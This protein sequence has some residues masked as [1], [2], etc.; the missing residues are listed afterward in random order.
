MIRCRFLSGDGGRRA[1]ALFVAALSVAIWVVETG[2]TTAD[3]RATDF[4]PDVPPIEDDPH[5][6]FVAPTLPLTPEEQREKFQLPPGFEIQLVVAEP[7][8][9]KPMNLNFDARGRLW[10]THSVEYPWPAKESP[11]RDGLTVLG[12]IGADGRAGSVTR[13]ADGL[14]IP[15]GVLP[16]PGGVLAYSIPTIDFFADT[17][18]DGKADE[19][20]PYYQSIEYR[21]THGMTNSFTRWIDGWIYACHGFANTSHLRGSDGHEIVMNSGNTYRMR[22]DGSHVEYFTHGQVNPF[23][24]T[25]D[26][27][28]N[29]YSSDCHTKPLYQLLRGA[30]YPSFGK[31]HDGLGFGPTTLEHLHGSTGIA[32]VVYYAAEQFPAKYCDTIFI[33]NPVTGRINHDRLEPHG[34]SY[35]AIEQP[36]FV[37]CEDPWFRPV[38]I[39]LGPDGAMY[40]ADFYNCIIGHYEVPLE[41]PRRD[42]YRGRIWRVVYRGDEEAEP[43]A[44]PNFTSESLAELLDRLADE[45]LTV[46]VMATNEICDRFGKQVET[47][48]A[49]NALLASEEST[50]TQRAHGM[51]IVER[52]GGL[53]DG[54]IERFAADEGRLVRV[55]VTKLLAERAEWTSSQA[56]LASRLLGDA[57]PFVRRAA[58]DALGRHPRRE[59]VEPLLALWRETP[60]DDTHLI[61][62]ARMALRDHLRVPGMYAEID[63]LVADDDVASRIA[64]L[65]IGVHSPESAAFVLRYLIDG[66]VN[67]EQLGNMLH[68]AARYVSD[69]Q[70]PSIFAYAEVYD[71]G[72]VDDQVTVLRAMRN[73]AQE[74]GKP[75]FEGATAWA[76]RLAGK[77]LGSSDPNTTR[78]GIELAREFGMPDAFGRIRRLAQAPKRQDHVRRAAMEALVALDGAR[79]EQVLAELLAAIDERVTIRQFAANKLAGLN[80]ES[81]RRILL[82]QLTTAPAQL[83]VQIAQVL[84]YG[85]DGAVALLEAVEAGKASARLLKETA[86]ARQLTRHNIPDRDEQVE[87][88]TASLPPEDDRIQQLIAQRREHFEQAS[89]DA[90]RGLAVYQ[91]N[92]SACHRV[93]NEGKKIGP[94]LDGVGLRGPER[95]IEDL[96]DPSRNVDQA[97][98]ATL[99]TTV[100]GRVVSGLVLR[101]EGNV[102]ILADAEGKEVR[103]PMDEIDERETSPLSPMPANVAELVSPDDFNHLLAFLLEQR[104]KPSAADGE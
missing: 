53:S 104:A 67:R 20:T 73:A 9:Q 76:Q 28:G 51:W 41:H 94:E 46:R 101:E 93:G 60:S 16:L 61:H 7:Q 27:L 5:G 12:E 55:H 54:Q 19:R 4:P 80:R 75:L 57:D 82:D 103:V 100:D 52:L 98:R 34:S 38:D 24:L 99:L 45:N 81:A 78:T 59:Q 6:A 79:A 44:I 11:G 58:A 69:D 68:Y 21:D 1:V 10:V 33:G 48:A 97:F 86:V 43:P 40:I 47:I 66:E 90:Q 64:E 89:K 35:R 32:G 2:R 15:I 42:R 30:W 14:N 39:Q 74:R 62:T 84:C 88:L 3:D 23:G 31:P 8:I 22:A 18:N 77:L 71:G 92:C 36:D 91:K 85:H 49:V 65:S 50:A 83:S 102:L 63:E 87:R 37:S 13:F 56:A 95:L 26:P 17:D 72:D 25:F 70:W 96:L 29:L